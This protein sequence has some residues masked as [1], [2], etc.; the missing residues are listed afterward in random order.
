VSGGTV[1]A[2]VLAGRGGIR[3]ERALDSVTWAPRRVVVD[4]AARLAAQTLPPGVEHVP[5]LAEVADAAWLLLLHESEAATPALAD[6]VAAA[7]AAPRYDAYRVPRELHGFGL[8]LRA[9][10]TPVRLARRGAALAV[11][12]GLVPALALAGVRPGRLAAALVADVGESL[13][14]AVEDLEADATV[15][16]RVLGAGGQ[17][18]RARSA[19]LAAVVSSA[20]IV[21]ARR[22]RD[23]PRPDRWARWVLATLGGYCPMAA[24]T[25]LWELHQAEAAALR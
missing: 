3:L 11:G 25:K 18:A 4:P 23:V 20:R 14:T 2:V 21:F 13:A 5:S 9:A 8:V 22:R 24:Y 19:A 16:A 12:G 10:G 17:R 6:A 7:T 1:A 15:L